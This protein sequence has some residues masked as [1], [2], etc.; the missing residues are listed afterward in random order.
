MRGKRLVAFY[1]HTSIKVFG[2]PKG[3]ILANIYMSVC[4]CVRVCA[5]ACMGG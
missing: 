4:L 3:V 2:K 1:G 5:R